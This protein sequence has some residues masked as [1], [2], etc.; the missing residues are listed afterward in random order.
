MFSSR[1]EAV[2][3]TLTGNSKCNT[4]DGVIG[5]FSVTLMNELLKI[6]FLDMGNGIGNLEIVR[7]LGS[8]YRHNTTKSDLRDFV[9]DY[10]G[11]QVSTLLPSR[12]ISQLISVVQCCV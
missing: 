10:I 5:T 4:V 6:D 3:R 8:L 7:G 1:R 12:P 9:R 11:V 2:F